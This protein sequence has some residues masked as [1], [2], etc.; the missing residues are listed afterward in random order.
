MTQRILGLSSE[1]DEALGTDAPSFPYVEFVLAE[2]RDLRDNAFR[3]AI[4]DTYLTAGALS[5]DGA[6]GLMAND[7][8]QPGRINNQELAVDPE[9]F[10][11]PEHIAPAN[12]TIT[13]F[14]DGSFN[15]TPDPGFTGTDSFTYRLI[16]RVDDSAN[17]IGD[18]N[19]RSEPA[20]VGAGNCPPD[21]SGDGTVDLADLNIVL[22][23]FGQTTSDGDT[24]GDG[25]V[26]LADL[27]AV[28]GA[29]GQA[30]P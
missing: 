29:F 16:A 25:E 8:G 23:N 26:D 15:Y 24:N 30:C 22:G 9:F 27:N 2:L 13:V 12:G 7:V 20:T 28:L 10:S 1:I 19:V 18:P 6:S 4:D 14:D 17:P 5:V 3:L 21:V 11:L